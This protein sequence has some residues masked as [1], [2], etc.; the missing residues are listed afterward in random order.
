MTYIAR[1]KQFPGFSLKFMCVTLALEDEG[2][3][4]DSENLNIP[5]P[6]RRTFKIHLISIKEN[7]SFDPVPVTPCS[8]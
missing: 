4:S 3:E 6:L 2:Y 8:T 1:I 7:V 5:T